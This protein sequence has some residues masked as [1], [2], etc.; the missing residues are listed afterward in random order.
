MSEPT[1]EITTNDWKLM[2][3]YGLAVMF[4]LLGFGG[5]VALCQMRTEVKLDST[6]KSIAMTIQ[7]TT[8]RQQL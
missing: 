1:I 3:A 2:V 6:E 8:K 5:C 7:Q 4:M